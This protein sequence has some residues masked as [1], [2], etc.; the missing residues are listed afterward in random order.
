MKLIPIATGEFAI[1]DDQDYDA[2]VQYRW[3]LVGENKCVYRFFKEQRVAYGVAMTAMIMNDYRHVY[4][5]RDRNTL[6][7][8]RNN[9]RLC[10][11]SQNMANRKKMK[12]CTSD[13]KGVT[14]HAPN[15]KWRA[16]ISKDGKLISLGCHVTEED[17]VRAYDEAALRLFGEFALLNFPVIG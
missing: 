7:N 14:F 3:V 11:H 4:D 15:G 6:N 5:H 16:R 2:L 17:A 13:Y 9:I 12:D 10:T 1:V 8:Q